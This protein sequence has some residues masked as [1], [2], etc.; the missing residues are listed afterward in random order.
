MQ[1]AP[2]QVRAACMCI[3]V[4]LDGLNT[5]DIT[6]LTWS[7]AWWLPLS[8]LAT[9]P[10]GIGPCVQCPSFPCACTHTHTSLTHP[11][12]K[13]SLACPHAHAH[14]NVYV[15]VN[16]HVH[17]HAHHHLPTCP[18]M[19]AGRVRMRWPLPSRA[20]PHACS[21]ARRMHAGGTSC[22]LQRRYWR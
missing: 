3:R 1:R 13:G 21:C 5:S 10:A 9:Y 7:V 15:H 8:R 19:H 4:Y 20:V 17:V 14:D 16:V 22:V 18:S 2:W 12:K 6:L 11:L